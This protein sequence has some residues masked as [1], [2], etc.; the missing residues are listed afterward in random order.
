MTQIRRFDGLSLDDTHEF[1]EGEGRSISESL[2][3]IAMELAALN[4]LLRTVAEN[5]GEVEE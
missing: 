4:Q 1:S 5:R 2:E 3:V